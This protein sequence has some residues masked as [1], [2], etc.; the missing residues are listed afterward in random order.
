MIERI[1]AVPGVV[2]AAHAEGVPLTFFFGSWKGDDLRLG[3]SEAVHAEYARNRV[4]PGYFQTM[5]IAVRGRVF[6]DDDRLGAP[7]VAIVNEEFA[8]QYFGDHHPIGFEIV[9]PSDPQAGIQRVIGVAANSKYRMIGEAASPALYE[10]MLQHEESERRTHVVV[11]IQAPAS[12]VIPAVRQV[13]LDVD[14][15]AAVTIEPMSSA[16]AFAFLPSRIGAALLGTIGALGTL[17]AMVGLFGILSFSVSRRTREIGLRMSLG[18]SRS[19]VTR[20]VVGE[21]GLLVCLGVALG[22][23]VAL[24]VTRPLAAFLVTGLETSDPASLA[25][26]V[27][28][29][30]ALS[31]VAA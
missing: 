24:F 10:P 19:A 9:D 4:G 3:G 12:T 26:T 8:R 23:G 15:S 20:L 17:L 21:A 14:R 29:L 30:A 13:M 22:L 11:R 2:S 1:R 27:V 7:R 31:L 28:A 6:T 25:G 18:A 16:L 5:G